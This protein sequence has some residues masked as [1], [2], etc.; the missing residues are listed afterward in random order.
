MNIEAQRASKRQIVHETLHRIGGVELDVPELESAG[1]ELGYRNRITVTLRRTSAGVVAGFRAYDDPET[2]VDLADCLLAEEPVRRAL[3]ELRSGWGIDACLLPAGGEL[4]ITI[5]AGTGGEVALLVQGGESN[6]P[7]DPGS[8][9]Q[10]I[11]GLASY[12]WIDSNGTHS[13]LAGSPR[14]M[15]YWQGTWIG[16]GPE[17]FLQV[18]RTV[19]DEMD[20]FLDRCVGPRNGLRIADLYAGAGARA[21]RWAR[22]GASVVAVESD[23]EACAAA[24]L[25]A[26]E[27]G[28]DVRVVHAPVES[29]GESYFD[30]E[31][32]VVNPPRAG[33]AAGVAEA[34]VQAEGVRRMA[35]V[36]CDPAKLARDLS[37]LSPAWRPVTVRAFDAFPQT[38][39][40]ETVVWLERVESDSPHDAESQ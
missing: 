29:A 34:L 14:F 25:A 40:V 1:R 15:D 16:L 35:Y 7:G 33:L 31:V 13:N 17:S 12:M 3:R 38:A 4:R 6:R 26:A 21:L 2:V 19:S 37:R 23:A 18:N 10:S 39:H 22:D 8:I 9:A 36:S 20:R 28:L 27:S 5:R 11:S 24:S 32:V 30:S